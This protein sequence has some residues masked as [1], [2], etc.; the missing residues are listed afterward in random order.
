MRGT[1][2]KSTVIIGTVG[3]LVLGATGACGSK[4]SASTGQGAASGS[5]SQ[6]L[7]AGDGSDGIDIRLSNGHEGVAPYDRAKLAPAPPT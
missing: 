7:P 1:G 5:A 3:L 4:H 6:P 2:V